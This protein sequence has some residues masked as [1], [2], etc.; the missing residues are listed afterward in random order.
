MAGAISQCGKCHLTF[1]SVEAF[2]F[3]RGDSYE[4]HTRRCL[5]VAQMRAKGM[6]LDEHGRWKLP[7]R[8]VDGH[9]RKQVPE[10]KSA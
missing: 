7:A 5:T 8:D 9:R 1:T 10:Q 6:A 2:D 4:Q 3:H